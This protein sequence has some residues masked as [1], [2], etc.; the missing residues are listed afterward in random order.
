MV[1]GSAALALALTSVTGVSAAIRSGESVI[2]SDDFGTGLGKW[3]RVVGAKLDESRGDH[4]GPPSVRTQAKANREY[5]RA[6]LGGSYDA[7]CTATVS[8]SGSI[9]LIRLTIQLKRLP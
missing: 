8:G 2:F 3:F 7:V 9:S 6:N 5:L 4:S 1:K